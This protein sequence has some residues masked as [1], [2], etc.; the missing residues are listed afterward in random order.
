[1]LMLGRGENHVPGLTCRSLDALDSAYES[2]RS[3]PNNEL[4]PPRPPPP[5]FVFSFL[6][7][8][9]AFLLSLG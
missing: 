5:L 2:R 4:N 6:L 3:R 9:L 8:P 7:R 1:M